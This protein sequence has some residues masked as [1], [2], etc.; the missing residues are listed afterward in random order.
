MT[1]QETAARQAWLLIEQSQDIFRLNAEIATLKLQLNKPAPP[2]FRFWRGP[3][4]AVI[5][6]DMR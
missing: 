2:S 3:I 5:D 6:G 4:L 1:L